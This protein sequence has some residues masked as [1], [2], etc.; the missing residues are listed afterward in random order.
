MRTDKGGTTSF[1]RNLLLFALIFFSTVCQGQDN[2]YVPNYEG[3]PIRN[4]YYCLDFSVDHKQPRW[5][6]YMLTQTHIRGDA[7]RS[8]SFKDCRQDTV[9]SASTKDYTNSG[10][11]RGHLCPAADM[12]LSKGAMKETFQMWNISPQDQSF[13]RGRWAELEALVR[14]YIRDVSDTLFV[15]TGPIFI[16]NKEPIGRNSDVTV[17]GFFYKAVYCPKRGGIGFLM[18]N[19][20]ITEPLRVWIVPIN[21][22]EALTG[23]DFFPQIPAECQQVIESQVAWW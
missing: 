10:Y 8:S 15:V 19:R 17:P 12:K 22:I 13:N 6:Y 9:T 4:S 21:F 1:M 3:V 2:R 16:A 23:I 20:K 5:V 7:Q 18:P 14:S 11:D